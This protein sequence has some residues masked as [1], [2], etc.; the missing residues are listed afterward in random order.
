MDADYQSTVIDMCTAHKKENRHKG[1]YRACVY[2]DTHFVKY[3]PCKQL[4]PE[5]E[6]H[7]YMANHAL[8]SPNAPRVARISSITDGNTM[9]LLIE[10][11]QLVKH[12]PPD[13]HDRIC[14]AITWLLKTPAPPDHSLGPLGGCRIRHRFFKDYKAPLDFPD[15]AKLN[16]YIQKVCILPRSSSFC[17]GGSTA[18]QAVSHC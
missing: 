15:K 13:F 7:S 11:I 5:L 9:Y 17:L 6:M 4:E 1:D 2:T 3:G 8:I 10:R 12:P 18:L 16:E 14:Q